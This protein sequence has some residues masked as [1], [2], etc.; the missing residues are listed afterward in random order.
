MFFKK[1]KE[2]KDKRAFNVPVP[3][4]H[5]LYL[6][7]RVKEYEDHLRIDDFY[8]RVL[9][10]DALPEFVHFGWFN[11]IVAIGGLTVSVAL[12]PYTH[13]AASDRIQKERSKLGSELLLAQKRGDTTRVDVL[14]EKYEFYRQL[15]TDINLHRNNIMAV[16]VTIVVTARSYPELLYKCELVKDRLGATKAVTLYKRQLQG[17]KAALPLVEMTLPEYHDVTVANAACLAPLTGTNFSHPSGIYFGENETGS[18]VFLDLFIK[19]PR[20]FGPHMFITGTTRS[21]KSYTC[22]GITARSVASGILVVILDPEGEYKK[23]VRALGGVYVKIH[24]QMDCMFNVFDIEPEFE[25]NIGSYINIPGKQDDIVFLLAT[26]M[27][28]QTGE[29]MT[30]EERALA[31]EAVRLEYAERGITSDPESLFLPGGR[32]TE[33]GFMAGKSYKEMPTL[34]SYAERLK[35]L[36]AARLANVLLPFLKGGPQGYFDGQGVRRFYDNPLVCFDLSALTT[37]FSRMYAMYVMLSWVWEKF[38][39]R[40]RL[41]KKRVLVDEAWLF[42]RHKD[43]AEFLSQMARRGAKYKTSLMAA[44][45]S[46]REFTTEEGWVFLAQCDTKFFLRMQHTDAEALGRRFNLPAELVARMEGFAQGQ[47]LLQAGGESA[48]VRFKSFPFEEPFLESEET[49]VRV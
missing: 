28:V 47:G 43:T 26:V 3:E 21:G 25:E 18:P 12:S 16:L 14:G 10:V 23:I 31:G 38:V 45:Q 1:K 33:E 42:M 46:F 5:D 9:V 2:E 49:A 32:E 4:L 36:G 40:N 34:S 35:K 30:A 27:E 41:I 6:P 7:D 17:F 15:L 20:L 22:K 13:Q 44:S 11:S 29:K 39:K 48:I 37:E 24:P 19:P 8:C